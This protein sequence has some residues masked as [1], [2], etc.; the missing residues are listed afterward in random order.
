MGQ[1]DGETNPFQVEGF[2]QS[3]QQHYALCHFSLIMYNHVCY[4]HYLNSDL[5]STFT[6][7]QCWHS[8]KW[9]AT[10]GGN[11]V[12]V[13]PPRYLESLHCYWSKDQSYG[14]WWKRCGQ[15]RMAFQEL[16]ISQQAHKKPQHCGFQR[17]QHLY[18]L[19]YERDGLLLMYS[20]IA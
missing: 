19:F 17:F 20:C 2:K 12:E 6:L 9:S 15:G 16:L 13:C 5:S 8:F 1:P 18:F 10:V 4:A 11:R 3:P 7:T 14:G